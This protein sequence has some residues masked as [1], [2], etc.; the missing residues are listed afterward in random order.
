MICCGFVFDYF[1]V[2]VAAVVVVDVVA[3]HFSHRRK[4]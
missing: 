3:E 1:I 2:V 4:I